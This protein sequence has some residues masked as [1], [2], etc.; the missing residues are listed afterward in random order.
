VPRVSDS[1]L[2]D[3][4]EAREG[5]K[6][7]HYLDDAALLVEETLG[8]DSGL[9]EGRLKLIEKNLGAHLWVISAEK[10]GLQ[11]ERTLDAENVYQKYSGEG[12]SSTRFGRLVQTYDTTGALDKV[13]TNV[14]KAQLRVV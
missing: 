6:L 4:V 9:S 13:L 2:R 5:E 11:S 14:K 7:T 8:T 10:G 3:L 12:L 1:E